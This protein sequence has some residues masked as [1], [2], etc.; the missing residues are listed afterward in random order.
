M[1]G[2]VV[3]VG[4][5]PGA[6]DLLTV[7]AV[8]EL[9]RADV[10]LYDRLVASEVLALIPAGVELVDV[11]KRRGDDQTQER[12][13]ELMVSYALAGRRVVRLKGGDPLVFG[14]GGE[15]LEILARHGIPVEVVPGLTSA[16]SVPTDIGLPLT[17]R[18]V[19]AGFAVVAGESL[20]AGDWARYAGVDTLVVLM[21]VRRRVEIAHQLIVHGRSPDEASAFI[22][23][24]TTPRQRTVVTTLAEIAEKGT[25][26]VAPAVWVTGVVVGAFVS[27]QIDTFGHQVLL[28]A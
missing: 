3:L 6:A 20:S 11:G 27:R 21:G 18:G 16:V 2:S 26:V 8:T 15:E 1:S 24:G 14:R 25:D 17:L 23:S 10:V 19:A 22:E 5:G 9:Q 28:E 4:A 12:I 7:R 13:G